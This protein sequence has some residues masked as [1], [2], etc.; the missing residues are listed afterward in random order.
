MRTPVIDGQSIE[1]FI[2][3]NLR[4]MFYRHPMPKYKYAIHNGLD[5]YGFSTNGLVL[6]LPLWAL[7]NNVAFKSVDAYKHTVTVSGATNLWQPDGRLFAGAEKITCGNNAALYP[8]KHV[9]V[10]T[11]V[12]SDD[13]AAV[14]YMS[15]VNGDDDSAPYQLRCRS[16]NKDVQF[17]INAGHTT[18]MSV[19]M[20]NGTWNHC[21]GTYDQ[22]LGS[23][24]IK[25]YLNK[26]VGTAVNYTTE[27]TT[28]DTLH[29]GSRAAGLYWVGI[30][31]EVWI[32][33]R[34][35]SAGEVAHNYNSTIWRYQ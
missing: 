19:A 17:C 2:P 28:A 15:I 25:M 33:N 6:Y 14:N 21:A 11:W 32:Y 1:Q 20:V 18:S 12:Y 16:T 4:D 26:A 7:K 27:I 9:T 10:I 35:L 3:A 13:Y 31:G 34:T 22:T 23:A 30:I 5:P 8:A 29:I 24:N